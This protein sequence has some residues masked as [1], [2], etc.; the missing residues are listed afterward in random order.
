MQ[1]IKT[2][3]AIA[4]Y[5]A[6]FV[7]FYCLLDASYVPLTNLMG[8]MG[9]VLWLFGFAVPAGIA[10]VW[11]GSFLAPSIIDWVNHGAIYE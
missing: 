3:I 5:I 10:S 1:T 11:L 4:F 6:S 8:S 9:P 2:L 7:V